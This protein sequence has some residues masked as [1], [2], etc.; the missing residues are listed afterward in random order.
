M[1]SAQNLICTLYNF[2]D[3]MLCDQLIRPAHQP[4]RSLSR[5]FQESS[6]SPLHSFFDDRFGFIEAGL[7]GLLVNLILLPDFG[8]PL[9]GHIK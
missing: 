7:A 2:L 3:H 1:I 9:A 6:L 4:D 8:G 5:I